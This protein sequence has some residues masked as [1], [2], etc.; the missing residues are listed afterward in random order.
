MRV[1][2]Y[3]GTF[4][5]Q[6]F[7]EVNTRSHVQSGK[8]VP[9]SGV[10]CPVHAS[11]TSCC[12]FVYLTVHTVQSTVVQCLY[13]KIHLQEDDFTEILAVQHEELTTKDVMELEAQRQDEQSKR[14]KW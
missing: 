12:A 8:L 11:F 3:T 5:F 14:K 6:A 1:S 7:K 4:K 10:R 9:M 13:F 2:P